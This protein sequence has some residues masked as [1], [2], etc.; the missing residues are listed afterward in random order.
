MIEGTRVITDSLAIS[1][2]VSKEIVLDGSA[3][4]M[5]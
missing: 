1:L 4:E 2:Y 3:N 5:S